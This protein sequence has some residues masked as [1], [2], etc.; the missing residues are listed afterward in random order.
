MAKR[1]SVTTC[2]HKNFYYNVFQKEK[3]RISAIKGRE[4]TNTQFSE[5]LANNQV[6]FKLPRRSLRPM[7]NFKIRGRKF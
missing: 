3:D 2:L 4:F 6:Q 1:E 5:F 7:L